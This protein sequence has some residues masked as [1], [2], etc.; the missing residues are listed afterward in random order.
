MSDQ[1]TDADTDPLTLTLTLDAR[2]ERVEGFDDGFETFLAATR[3][4][5]PARGEATAAVFGRHAPVMQVAIANALREGRALALLEGWGTSR[6]LYRADLD[7]DLHGRGP[8]ASIRVALRRVDARDAHDHDGL[9]ADALLQNLTELIV[10]VDPDLLVRAWNAPLAVAAATLL[11]RPLAVGDSMKDLVAPESLRAWEAFCARALR[12]ESFVDD[13]A[14]TLTIGLARTYELSFNP[15]RDPRGA[16]RGALVIGRNVTDLR[17]EIAAEARRAQMKRAILD[18]I[19]DAI[20]VFARDGT[21]LD[22]KG[23]R[24]V[25]W[26]RADEQIIGKNLRDMTHFDIHLV[27]DALERAFAERETVQLEYGSTVRGVTRARTAAL[28]AIGEDEAIIIIRDI[29]E[30]RE[31]ARRLAFANRMASLGTLAAGVAHELNNPLTY[32]AANLDH[33]LRNE[34]LTT[35]GEGA[36][37]DAL[38]GLERMRLIVA[39]LRTFSHPNDE[40]GAVANLAK[41]VADAVRLT[42]SEV[43][44]RSTLDVQ[45]AAPVLVRGSESRLTQVV[46]NLLLNAVH[47]LTPPIAKNVVRVRV[48]VLPE[49]RAAVEVEDNGP[50]VPA[51]IRERIFDPFFTTKPVGEGTGLGLAIAQQIVRGAGGELALASAPG[52]GALFRAALPLAEARPLTR[53][54][55]SATA[56]ILLVDDEPSVRAGLSRLLSR[57]SV[58][59]VGS[60]SEAL[61][62]LEEG[63]FDL[64][65]TDVKMP[66]VGGVELFL[67]VAARWPDRRHRVVLMTG[68]L[69]DIEHHSALGPNKPPVL[70][71]PF[72]AQSVERCLAE[73]RA[74]GP[75]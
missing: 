39:N 47:G 57:W 22:F 35:D 7:V 60:V 36:L 42:K 65:L 50:G 37:A 21:I 54:P 73:A 18:A 51:A 3:G 11:G 9:L 30:Q 14:M 61:V 74:A 62:L 5:G 2:G 48:V 44:T 13:H 58:T 43:L 10:V 68:G 6:G 27:L 69:L 40:P 64:I 29:T 15:I 52:E 45:A 72:T 1:S 25:P 23:S 70:Q 66:G 56:R 49:G 4:H 16:I 12:G 19:P 38:E 8:D 59:A 17:A 53:W 75:A 55:P 26:L 71:K 24:D 31:A 67:Q 33:M 28:R 34:K 32:V 46:V 41:V 20:I 63:D